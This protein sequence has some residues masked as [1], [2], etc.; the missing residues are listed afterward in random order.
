MRSA[1]HLCNRVAVMQEGTIVEIFSDWHEENLKH[2]IPNNYLNIVKDKYKE[3]VFI[4]ACSFLFKEI[5]LKK[6]YLNPIF[7]HQDYLIKISFSF[8]VGLVVRLY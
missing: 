5:P 2:L 8:Q 7:Y 4:N 1:K 3:H 6:N